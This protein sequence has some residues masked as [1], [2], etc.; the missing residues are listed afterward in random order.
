M[1]TLEVGMGPQL[2]GKQKNIFGDNYERK[3]DLTSGALG[4]FV[5]DELQNISRNGLS[6]Q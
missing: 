6:S 2:T 3:E 1:A 4:C 5:K